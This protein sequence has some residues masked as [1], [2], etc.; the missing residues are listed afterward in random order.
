MDEKPLNSSGDTPSED[1]EELLNSIVKSPSQYGIIAT[2]KHNKILLW[3]AGATAIYGYTA[4]EMIEKR[5]PQE[6]HQKEKFQADSIFSDKIIRRNLRDSFV[7]GIRKDGIR[8]PVSVT[9]SPRRNSSNKIVGYFYIVRD[10]TKI[11][12]QE[13]FRDVLLEIAHIV[14]STESIEDMCQSII[15]C[16]GNF[17]DLKVIFI[18]LF[19]YLNNDFQIISQVGLKEGYEYHH[20]SYCLNSDA[21]SCG[22]LGCHK[23]YMDMSMH[24]EHIKQHSIYDY[25]KLS[26]VEKKHSTII[27]IPLISEVSLLGIIH[28]IV[29]ENKEDLF[30]KESQILSIISNEITAGIRRR[31]L[32]AEIK[33]YADNLEKMVKVRTE[34]LRDKDAQLIQSGK[35]ATLGELAAGIAHEINQPLGAI[36]LM[37]EGLLM[38]K[39][40]GKLDDTLLIDKLTDITKQVERIN[41]IITHLRTF[42]RQTDNVKEPIDIRKPLLDVF[43]II[44]QQLINKEIDVIIEVNEELPMILAEHTR[45]EQI[46]LNLINNAKDAIEDKEKQL[47]ENTQNSFSTTPKAKM[48]KQIVV[49]GYSNSEFLVIEISDNG[50]GIPSNILAKVFDPFFTT[51]EVGKGTGLGLSIT[52]GIVKDFG[53]TIEIMSEKMNGAVFILRFPIIKKHQGDK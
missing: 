29:P 43:K 49:K 4:E 48:E 37:S 18:C 7:L 2:D 35:L 16:V 53:G 21:V 30:L 26:S 47:F 39:T 28:I 5:L 9:I 6:I 32:V 36:S 12:L 14:N 40:R 31:R 27:H 23:T 10:I 52:Y 46:F 1:F 50:I 45:L 33:Q 34:Q 19:D 38:A 15:Q 42:A 22:K 20:C 44:G 24:H 41:K 51:K 3:N 8:V 25:V 11:R 13:Q 17:F